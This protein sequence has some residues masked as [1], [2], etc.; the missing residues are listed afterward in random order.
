MRFSGLISG[1]LFFWS[2]AATAGSP[3]AIIEDVTA[4]EAGVAF[5]DYVEAGRIIPLGDD[6]R[7]VIGYLRSCLRETIIGGKVTV[8]REKSIVSGGKLVRERVEC[9]GG[10]LQLSQEQAGKSAV[11]V[12]RRP[13]RPA[14]GAMPRAKYKIYSTGPYFR[15]RSGTGM[16]EIERLDRPAEVQRLDAVNGGVDLARRGKAL[17]PGGL[18]R[19][20]A[21]GRE[22]V[23][24]VV[25]HAASGGPILGRLVSF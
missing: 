23:F 13:P 16:V 11:V 24:R 15:L 19:A 8:G 25:A 10:K 9:D 6:G 5:M 1:A 18:Y 21:G 7:L 22:I 2:A 3:A 20:R 12:F 17:R 14:T 4:K